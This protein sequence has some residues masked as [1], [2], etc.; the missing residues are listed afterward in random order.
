MVSFDMVAGVTDGLKDG[1]D[2]GVRV[3]PS[4]EESKLACLG[5]SKDTAGD[6]VS[7]DGGLTSNVRPATEDVTRG[8]TNR[9]LGRPCAGVLGRAPGA[10]SGKLAA[11]LGRSKS[12]LAI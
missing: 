11:V 10:A 5:G 1:T 8:F 12:G 6:V 3:R 4:S 9:V 2:R 7:D